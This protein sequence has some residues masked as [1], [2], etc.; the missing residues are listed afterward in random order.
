MNQNKTAAK[1]ALTQFA[2]ARVQLIAELK[3]AGYHTLEQCKPIVIEWA[4]DKTGAAFK[5]NDETGKVSMVS[6][7]AKYNTAK[8][9]VRDVMLMIAGTTRRTSNG[10]S[11]TEPAELPRAVQASV[12]SLVGVVIAAK[13]TRAEFDALVSQ[14]RASVD[15]K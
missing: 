12:K 11:K 3:K 10:S 4:C 2:S 1:F 15:F 9:V 14:L 13:L 7:H 8:T 5:V 6:S